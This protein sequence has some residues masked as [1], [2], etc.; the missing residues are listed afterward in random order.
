[1]NGKTI[2]SVFGLAAFI[3][4]LLAAVRTVPQEPVAVVPLPEQVR[5]VR[6]LALGDV[7]LGRTV[8]QVLLHGDTLHPF[9]FVRDSLARYDVVFAN[10]ESVLSDQGGETESPRSNMVFTGPPVGALSLKLGGVT[11]VS[12]ANNHALDYGP[13]A[14]EETCRLL[15]EAGIAHAGT[16]ATKRRYPPA[17][18]ERNGI[19]IALFAVTDLMNGRRG[20]WRASVA[21]ADT[22]RLLPAIRGIRDSVDVVCVSYHGGEEYA[23][24]PARA[25]VRFMDAVAAGGAD[26]VFGHHPHVPYG[27]DRPDGKLIVH[28]LG[29]FVFRQ[30]AR[31]WTQRGLAV[32]AELVKDSTGTRID[33]VWCIPVS[34]GFQPRFLEPGSSDADSTLRRVAQLKRGRDRK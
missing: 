12:V 24:R 19:R 20:T 7:N 21:A 3:G 28:S 33:S 1:V 5:R 25:S 13:G 29:N 27:I 6:L 10:L 18:V 22:G 26:L 31:F 11:M 32:G 4:L 2:L 14:L 23:D 34:A 30:P 9:R 17:V 8:G 15:D 16:V